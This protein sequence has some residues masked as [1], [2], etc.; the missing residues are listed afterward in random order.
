M[1][2]RRNGFAADTAA[3]TPKIEPGKEVRS[4]R[5]EVNHQDVK[6]SKDEIKF[7]VGKGKARAAVESLRTQFRDAGWEEKVAS[8]ERMTGTLLLSKEDQSVTITYSDTGFMPSEISL[9][10]MRAE[11]EAAK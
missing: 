4:R 8:L 3:A 5:D 10:A 11:L 1:T 6:Q 2:R 7:T 9:S